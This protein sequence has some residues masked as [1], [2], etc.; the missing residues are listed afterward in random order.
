MLLSQGN[1]DR[2]G[3]HI[4]VDNTTFPCSAEISSS[5]ASNYDSI[6][7]LEQRFT[8]K[9]DELLHEIRH[10]SKA[11]EET[12]REDRNIPVNENNK[13]RH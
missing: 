6:R 5:E 1:G 2:E 11:A 13:F 9:F 10:P 7:D 12:L 3:K 8:N 4:N